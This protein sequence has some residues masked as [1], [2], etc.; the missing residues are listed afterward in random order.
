MEYVLRIEKEIEID[1]T[2]EK[3]KPTLLQYNVECPYRI[4]D[5][6]FMTIDQVNYELEKWG[7]LN[8]RGFEK[9]HLIAAE[10]LISNLRILHDHNILHNAIHFQNYTWAL[11]LLVFE[12]ARTNTYP[13]PNER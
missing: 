5:F 3:L 4:C 12:L 9:K 8:N 13:Y 10:V 2:G 7:S 6:P 1:C 11:E